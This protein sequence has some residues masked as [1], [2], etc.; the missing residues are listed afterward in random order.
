MILKEAFEEEKESAMNTDVQTNMG[1]GRIEKR[2]CRVITD[3]DWICKSQD[4]KGLRSIV[5]I[6]AEQTDKKPVNIKK[7]NVIIFLIYSTV[8]KSYLERLM[9]NLKI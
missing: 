9:I 5:E 7:N 8:S 1:H 6:T 2:S 4:W 3:M